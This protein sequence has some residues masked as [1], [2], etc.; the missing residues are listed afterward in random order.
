[1]AFLAIGTQGVRIESDPICASSG[2]DHKGKK[3]KYPVD[4]FV[5]NLGADHLI[6]ENHASLDWAQRSLNHTWNIPPPGAPLPQNYFVPSF[7]RDSDINDSLKSMQD[8]EKAQKHAWTID[9]NDYFTGSTPA[10]SFVQ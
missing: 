7:G 4:Y 2:C 10:N 1:M 5:P 9:P 8:Q 3:E 6:N